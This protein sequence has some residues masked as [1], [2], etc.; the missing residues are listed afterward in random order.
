MPK[1]RGQLGLDGVAH[2]ET[3]RELKDFIDKT[4]RHHINLSAKPMPHPQHKKSIEYV[5]DNVCTAFKS[6]FSNPQTGKESRIMLKAYIMSTGNELRQR[7]K[8]GRGKVLENLKRGYSPPRPTPRPRRTHQVDQQKDDNAHRQSSSTYCLTEDH[9]HSHHQETK[10]KPVVVQPPPPP[11]RGTLRYPPM[12]GLSNRSQQVQDYSQPRP[13]A[14]VSDSEDELT[15][16]PIR[17]R[18]DMEHEEIH[19]FLAS[20]KPCLT[21]LYPYL[22]GYGCTDT[23]YL[24][25]M[26]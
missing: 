5:T 16:K 13:R 14:A 23:D 25:V 4:V 8:L 11:S 3:W 9:D 18:V 10:V 26:S 2:N 1:L 12:P 6:L 7:Q 21:H 15:L 19:D 24:K 22:V 20:C 17:R